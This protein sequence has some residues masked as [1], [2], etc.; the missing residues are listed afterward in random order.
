MAA[1]KEMKQGIPLDKATQAKLDKTRVA[2]TKKDEAGE[3]TGQ[4]D[5]WVRCPYCGAAC[6]AQ[7]LNHDYY[8]TRICWS[9]GQAFLA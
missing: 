1:P 3:V 4:Y 2:P 8:V 7:G 9:C 6:W 5:A